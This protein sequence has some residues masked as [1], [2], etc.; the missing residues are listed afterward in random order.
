[1]HQAR[2]K[3][4]DEPGA[5]APGRR[6]QFHKKLI[7]RGCISGRVHLLRVRAGQETIGVLYNL[8]QNGKVYFYQSGFQYSGARHLKPGLVTHACAIQHYLE[9]GF[10]DYDFLAGDARYKTS[11]ATAS[12][13]MAWTVFARP[14]IKLAGIELLRVLKR[15]IRSVI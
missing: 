10:T 11:L 2:R 15:R 6:L 7:E 1:M 3:A 13:P 5:F 4:R 8:V 9:L 14:R 12:R